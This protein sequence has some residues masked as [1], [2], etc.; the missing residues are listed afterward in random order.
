MMPS[1]H[2][3]F[4]ASE[5]LSWMLKPLSGTIMVSSS[6]KQSIPKL[7][8]K[9]KIKKVKFNNLPLRYVGHMARGRVGME[10]EMLTKLF[11][12]KNKKY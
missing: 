12:C 8:Y 9:K 2:L 3:G 10:A 6:T 4:N 1:F 5:I 11:K 7:K